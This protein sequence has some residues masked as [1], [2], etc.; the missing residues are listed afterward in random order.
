MTYFLWRDFIPSYN[1]GEYN[2]EATFAQGYGIVHVFKPS[3]PEDTYVNMVYTNVTFVYPFEYREKSVQQR[4]GTEPQ[5]CVLCVLHLPECR[6]TRSSKQHCVIMKWLQGRLG[7]VA[8]RGWSLPYGLAD[9]LYVTRW[10]TTAI[11]RR[12]T[13]C[14]M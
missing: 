6:K 2:E 5:M 13:R 11:S 12:I 3:D 7:F 8:F 9:Q 1:L 14:K 10:K 4:D